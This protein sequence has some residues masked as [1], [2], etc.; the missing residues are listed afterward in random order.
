MNPQYRLKMRAQ[1][2]VPLAYFV[3]VGFFTRTGMKQLIRE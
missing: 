3:S 1:D 2:G